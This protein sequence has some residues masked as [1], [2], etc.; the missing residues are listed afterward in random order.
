[1]QLRPESQP[2]RELA[3]PLPLSTCFRGNL[4]DSEPMVSMT[5]QPAHTAPGEEMPG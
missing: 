2:Q 1:M 4:R 5:C 3:A